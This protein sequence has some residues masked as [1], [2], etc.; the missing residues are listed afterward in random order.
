VVTPA[1]DVELA[2]LRKVL[3]AAR[4]KLKLYRQAHSGEYVGGMEYTALM[5]EI[6]EAIK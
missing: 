4:D 1:R 2:K 3:L 6:D 5:R